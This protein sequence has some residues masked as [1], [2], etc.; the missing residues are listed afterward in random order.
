MSS[1]NRYA[2][3][4]S[5][6]DKVRIQFECIVK[7][8]YTNS[9]EEAHIR[10]SFCGIGVFMGKVSH[11]SGD[12]MDIAEDLRTKLNNA[13]RVVENIPV[14]KA[15]SSARCKRPAW[16][17]AAYVRMMLENGANGTSSFRRTFLPTPPGTCCWNSTRRR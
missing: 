14:A 3:Q 13:L 11:L 10:V 15:A 17:N 7:L 9:C 1:P 12:L 16:V 6:M 8:R 5:D 4:R 2:R